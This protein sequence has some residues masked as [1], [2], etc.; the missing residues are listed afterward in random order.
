MAAPRD[1]QHIIVP[2][3][4][5]TTA[6]TPPP[7]DIRSLTP[8][9]NPDRSAHGAAL[10]HA[11]RTA[12]REAAERR[13]QAGIQV[14]GSKAGLY[15]EFESVEGIALEL[16]SLEATR[17]GIELVSVRHKSMA[18]EDGTV[19]KVE[20]ATVVVPEGKV[21]HF[22]NRFEAYSRSERGKG[23]HYENMVDRISRLRLATL[24]A[25]WT[26]TGS[27][28]PAEDEQR[29]WEVWLRKSDGHE[30]TRFSS[31]CDQLKINR[32]A[33][34]LEFEDR[35]VVL[36]HASAQGLALSLDVLN[37]L[38]ELRSVHEPA[39]FFSELTAGEQADWV[40]DLVER[41]IVPPEHAPAVCV[42]DTGINR[43]HPL[44]EPYLARTDLHACH[45]A[46]DVADHDGHGTEMAGL[47]LYGNLAPICGDTAQLTLRH[48]LESVK[49]LPPPG[50]AP[51]TPDLYGAVTAIAAST[52]ELAAPQR[53]R[54]FSIS[55]GADA[56]GERGQPTSWSAAIDALAAGRSF[57]A[58][59]QGLTYIDNAAEPAPGR[60]FLIAAG[61]IDPG[62][63]AEEYLV[64][65]DLNHVDDPAQAWNALAIGACTDLCETNDPAY[66]GWRPLAVAGELSPWS[67]TSVG[68]DM[69]WPNKPDVV[70][71]G[72]NV[73]HNG[74]RDYDHEAP[75]LCLLT[76]SGD[77]LRHSFS[78][79]YATSSACA[80]VARIAGE[81]SSEYPS[82]WPETVR[83]LIVHSAEWTDAMRQHL[84]ASPGKTGRSALVR[85]YGFGVPRVERALRSARDALTLLVQGKIRP[86]KKGKM[87]EI[88][89][90]RLPWPK[91]ALAG[92]AELGVKLRVT[93]SY[94][95]EPNPSRKGWR[96]KH[97][98]QSHGL[99][100]ALKGPTESN[101]EFHKRL[102]DEALD[103][104]EV[105]PA[106][107]DD[108]HWFLG[109][110]TRDRGSLHA[111]IWTGPAADLA[112]REIIA[113]YPVS[114]W[115][116]DQPSRDRSERGVR[117]ALVVSIETP[118][119][120]SDIW[121]P[122][123]QQVGI[124]IAI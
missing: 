121:T 61:N 91:A 48:R 82:L 100:F 47:A 36:V 110:R 93:L 34:R 54:C 45:P 8:P 84:A 37:D 79:S 113:V 76:T 4:P 18:R 75:D 115:W 120:E 74:A 77:Y 10:A 90:H 38:A 24:R 124:A 106:A 80:Q 68:F 56:D 30:F 15:V 27:D 99:R 81:I 39:R 112:E 6:Y 94:F 28:F 57:D 44:L 63:F 97:R 19:G 102:N 87:R 95:I 69:P 53:Q 122:V 51:N 31:Y 72:G 26:D 83:G 33:R 89:I 96:K 117:Y 103:M 17:S 62:N 109:A 55:V 49:I 123:A 25:L 1:R 21:K 43:G 111:D 5:Q 29:W 71:E 119:E 59:R 65:C 2:G 118:T 105:R 9:A 16:S 41:T 73:L 14:A 40:A 58:T 67:R 13:Q 98:Y 107:P 7:R 3:E 32:P 92:L 85:R 23:H 78:I 46:W 101:Q 116:K 35:I 114:G 42:L 88:Q 104:N 11:M 20:L 66:A 86:F 64:E 108:P 52:V 50:H 22:L 70:F 12:Q 60:L